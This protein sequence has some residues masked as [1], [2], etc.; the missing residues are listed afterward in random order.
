MHGMLAAA[1]GSMWVWQ[2]PWSVSIIA[3]A[4]LRM[5]GQL[6]YLV[7]SS[8]TMNENL[9]A[10]MLA[11]VHNLLVSVRCTCDLCYVV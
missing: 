5:A 9:F 8:L 2:W 11:N 3:G 4:V 10:V 1:L 7:L 6:G